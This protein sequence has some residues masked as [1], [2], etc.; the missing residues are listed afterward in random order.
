MDAAA[1]ASLLLFV[2]PSPAM[3]GTNLSIDLTVDPRFSI[4][5]FFVFALD[6]G[7]GVA[8]ETSLAFL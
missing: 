1:A 2:T 3:D 8:A 4:A 7:V 6:S 5:E